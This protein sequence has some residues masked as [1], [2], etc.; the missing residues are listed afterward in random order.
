MPLVLPTKKSLRKWALSVWTAG[1][2]VAER[3]L[4]F[5]LGAQRLLMW[6][7]PGF[8]KKLSKVLSSLR[9]DPSSGVVRGRASLGL[10]C[11]LWEPVGQDGLAV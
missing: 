10:F 11:R 4:G 5:S 9:T 1:E 7:P 3:L 6:H 8:L 2:V